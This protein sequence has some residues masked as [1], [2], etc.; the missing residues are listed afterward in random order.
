MLD[1][2]LLTVYQNPNPTHQNQFYLE[3]L[4]ANLWLP[5][6][7]NHIETPE[8]PF[9]PLI[10][11]RADCFLILVFSSL[12]RL[13]HWAGNEFPHLTYTQIT[14]AHLFKALGENVFLF[15]NPTTE[16]YKEFAPDEID[17][18]KNII[19]KTETLLKRH[20]KIDNPTLKE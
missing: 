10:S 3:L 4:K 17:H 5:T 11:E 2:A 15:L 16:F 9:R 19:A 8:E 13:Q 18:I 7:P 1:D 6:D 12:E 20:V 14:G